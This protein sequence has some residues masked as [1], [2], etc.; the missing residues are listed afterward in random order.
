MINETL[1]RLRSLRLTG[2]ADAL[3]QQLDQ[4]GTYSS[5]SFEERLALLTEQEETE[6]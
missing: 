6:R 2:M 5:L 1:A 3:N 4:P